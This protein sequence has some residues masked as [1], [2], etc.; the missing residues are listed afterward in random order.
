MVAKMPHKPEDLGWD[1][2][3]L[4]KSK[5]QRTESMTQAPRGRTGEQ[6]ASL[7]Q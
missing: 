1:P 2:Q 5:M 3:N 4:W 7:G 6:P